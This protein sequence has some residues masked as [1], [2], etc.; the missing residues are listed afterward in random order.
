MK[1]FSAI[2]VLLVTSSTVHARWTKYMDFGGNED[3]Y[4]TNPLNEKQCS[5]HIAHEVNEDGTRDAYVE[6]KQHDLYSAS[7]L[8][9]NFKLDIK[10]E[11][12]ND[13]ASDFTAQSL[14]TLTGSSLSAEVKGHSMRFAVKRPVGTPLN[15]YWNYQN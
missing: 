14:P 3:Q 12:R 2:I 15:C 1:K 9:S 10:G 6:F 7:T 13:G 11:V 8:A 4:Y 5:L